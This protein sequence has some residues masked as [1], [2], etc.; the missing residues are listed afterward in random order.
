MGVYMYLCMGVYIAN[1]VPYIIS[2]NISDFLEKSPKICISSLKIMAVK[3][4]K[5]L[6]FYIKNIYFT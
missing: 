5:L 1:L 6:I 2:Q 3:N 4:N